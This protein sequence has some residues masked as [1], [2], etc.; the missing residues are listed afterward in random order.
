[1]KKTY[2]CTAFDEDNTARAARLV[3]LEP[4]PFLMGA[5]NTAGLAR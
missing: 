3:Q 2:A 1:M 5:E 4:L